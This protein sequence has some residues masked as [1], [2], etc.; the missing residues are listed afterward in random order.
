VLAPAPIG[1]L[2]RVVEA[3]AAGQHRRGDRVCVALVVGVDE[4]DPPL[5]AALAARG[6]EPVL[7][8]IPPRGYLRERALLRGLLRRMRPEVLHTHG[9]RPDV[10]LSGVARREGIRVVTTVHGFTGGDWKNRLYERLQCRA[11]RR[12]DAVV[13]VSARLAEQLAA[14]GV[15]RRVI[16]SL[17]NAWGETSDPLP[18]PTARA[19]L[20]LPETGFLVGWVGRVSR[21]KGLDVAIEAL[22]LASRSGE[23]DVRLVVAGEGTERA[24]LQA[25][26][27]SLG[28][29]GRVRWL[30]TVRD[31]GRYFSAFD[32][33]LI[34]SRTEGTPVVL[35]EAMAAGVPVVATRVGGIPEVV[36]DSEALLVPSEQPEALA[37]ALHAL[38]RDPGAARERALAAGARLRAE[39]G[40]EPWI[41]R[42]AEVYRQA[43]IS[44]RS[45]V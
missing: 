44:S 12:F 13:A 3:L 27:A 8:R 42:Y 25:R 21:E 23:T 43:L 26:S 30:G 34:S 22:S 5:A 45:P 17:P 32:A 38:R 20:G 28:L 19:A 39:H 1:G 31:A 6:I 10:L 29:G 41:D 15:P 24:A 33:L 16:H 36:S 7:L 18:R 35:F 40:L 11:F 37:A 14:A 4:P 9:Y 2:E